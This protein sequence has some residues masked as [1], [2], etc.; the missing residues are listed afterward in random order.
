MGIVTQEPSEFLQPRSLRNGIARR[1]PLVS[2]LFLTLILFVGFDLRIGSVTETIVVQPLKADARDYFMYAYNLR[3]NK[4]YSRDATTLQNPDIRPAPDAVRSPGY[5]LF[6]SAFVHGLPNKGMIEK[7]VFWQALLSTVTVLLSFL[8]LRSFLSAFWAS[9][10]ALLIGLSPHLIVVNSYILTETLFC[11]ILVLIGWFTGLFGW[12]LRV[13]QAAVIGMLM[14]FASLVRPSLQYFPFLFCAFLIFHAGWRRG[15]KLA[16]VVIIAFALTFSPWIIRNM[17]TLGVTGDKTLMINF[18]H[19]GMYPDF[20]Y[21]DVQESRG[22]PYRYDPRSPEISQDIPSVLKEI[23][24]RFEQEPG[25]HLHW[26]LIGKPI[27]F[28]SWNTVQGVGDAFVYPVSQSPYFHNPYFRWSHHLMHA[29]HWPLVILASFGTVMV[30]L[31]LSRIGI[32]ESAVHTARFTSLL[33]IY[34]TALHVVGAPFPRYSIP[35]RPFLFGLALFPPYVL[36]LA[37]KSHFHYRIKE[38]PPS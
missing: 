2:L 5:P 20:T 15:G 37:L 14:A 32:K 11:F 36:T 13:W 9:V 38:S 35:L 16:A 4:V 29:L 24:R 19:H 8:F 26:F 10:A 31:P 1:T 18:L 21:G 27:A 12:R 33:L 6:L 3:H 17:H 23:A 7:V 30:W 22:F 34:Y 28:W 25:K